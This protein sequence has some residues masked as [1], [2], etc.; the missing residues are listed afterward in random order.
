MM[1]DKPGDERSLEDLRKFGALIKGLRLKKGMS[2]REFARRIEVSPAYVSRIERGRDNPP[3]VEILERMEDA[4][5]VDRGTL[6]AEAGKLPS[7]FVDVFTESDANREMMPLFMR[8]VQ[9]ADLSTEDWAKLIQN[10]KKK[11]G[12]GE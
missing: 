11:K 10:I 7:D 8:T 12:K 9:G 1:K 6:L 5:G 2:L 4:L 3:S